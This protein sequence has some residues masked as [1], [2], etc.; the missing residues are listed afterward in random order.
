MG[1]WSDPSIKGRNEAGNSL[2]DKRNPLLLRREGRQVLNSIL[3]IFAFDVVAMAQEL[4]C[5]QSAFVVGVSSCVESK[6][7]FNFGS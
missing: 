2:S 5:E 4:K 1:L 6:F 7:I 3:L